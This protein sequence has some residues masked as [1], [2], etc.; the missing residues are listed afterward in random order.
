MAKLASDS[1]VI[2]HWHHP[3]ENFQTSA[4]EFYA[5]V[6]QALAPR[7]IP[8]CSTSRID[9]YEGGVLWAVAQKRREQLVALSRERYARPREVVEAALHPEDAPAP[10]Q[11][12]LATVSEKREK[13]SP[14]A[15]VTE[16]RTTKASL[17]PCGSSKLNSVWF[18]RH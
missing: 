3:L 6:E 16:T 2:S 7:L 18:A 4:M 14:S 15:S 12:K 1:N 10:P 11:P 8:D 17:S 13:E 5:A 9:W